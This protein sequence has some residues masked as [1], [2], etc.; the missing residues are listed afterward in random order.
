MELPRGVGEQQP[1][2]LGANLGKERLQ[3]SHVYG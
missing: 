1:Q 2:Y 3:Q